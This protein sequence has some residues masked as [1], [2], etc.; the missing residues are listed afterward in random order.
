MDDTT[1]TYREPEPIT[2]EDV[3]SLVS[4]NDAWNISDN[5]SD[6]WN[7]KSGVMPY[8]GGGWDNTNTDHWSN[9]GAQALHYDTQSRDWSGSSYNPSGYLSGRTSNDVPITGRNTDEELSW[10]D[11]KEREK[12]QRPGPGLLP[13]ILA[14]ELHDSEHTLFSVTA[15]MPE[16]NVNP[17]PPPTVE[18]PSGSL[19][20]PPT[21]SP[22]S[23]PAASHKS[24]RSQATS[25]PT[26]EE[27]RHAVPHPNA[28]Y[29]P[30]ENGWVILSWKSSTVAPPLARS[31]QNSIHNPLPDQTQRKKTT[32]CLSEDELSFG[33]PNKTHHFH[34]YDKAVDALKLTPPYR[35]DEWE[36]IETVK[37]KRRAGTIIT[38]DLELGKAKAQDDDKMEE[39]EI[40]EEGQ[41]LDLYV[42]CQ[43]CFYCIGSPII[44]GVIPKTLW[45]DLILQKKSNPPVGVAADEAVVLGIE[46][47]VVYV[48]A[49]LAKNKPP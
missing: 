11:S 30:K 5:G 7:Q 28:Y 18:H 32:N 43:C 9:S 41:L 6:L 47:I 20:A 37:Q 23:S 46:T 21:S 12:H 34:K 49:H 27:V 16:Y 48:T 8:S 35:V 33:L 24:H 14:D 25:P 3:P 13:P 31:F 15:T 1:D 4:N 36:T 42:C 17:P 38:Q 40:E 29:C 39:D 26:E 44:P 10:W 22:S 19:N 45:N 2:D